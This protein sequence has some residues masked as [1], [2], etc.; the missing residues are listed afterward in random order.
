MRYGHRTIRH[1]DRLYAQGDVH[2]QT[3]EG[4]FGLL[5]NA[6]R[7]VHHGVSD[8]WLQGYLNEYCWRWNHRHDGREMFRT[9]VERSAFVS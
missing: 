8:K 9:L 5:K 3:I 7:G 2:T 6:L 1:R 4:F